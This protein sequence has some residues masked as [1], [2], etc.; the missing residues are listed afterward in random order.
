MEIGFAFL[1]FGCFLAV[2]IQLW[3]IATAVEEIAA[4]LSGKGK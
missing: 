4:T 3:R 2:V 1:L